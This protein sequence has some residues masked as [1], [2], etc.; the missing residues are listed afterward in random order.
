MKSFKISPINGS[1]ERRLECRSEIIIVITPA[2]TR[3]LIINKTDVKNIAR[4]YRGK[5]RINS[6][7]DN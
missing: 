7:K 5:T 2:D 3:V 6:N 4:Q 1:R